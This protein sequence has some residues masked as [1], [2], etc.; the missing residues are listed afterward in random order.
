MKMKYW[1]E[2]EKY[3]VMVDGNTGS[4]SG[5][6]LGYQAFLDF[7]RVKDALISLSKRPAGNYSYDDNIYKRT[8]TQSRALQILEKIENCKWDEGIRVVAKQ[9]KAGDM[10][11]PAR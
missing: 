6:R 9:I 1:S 8:I 7:K 10:L 5:A 3:I 4:V 11:S 2:H